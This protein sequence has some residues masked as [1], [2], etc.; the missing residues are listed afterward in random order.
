MHK[1]V[2]SILKNKENQILMIDRKNFPFG[3]ACPAGHVDK[4][5]TAEQA[6]IREV[7]EETG[8]NV[9]KYKLL[10]HEFV[11]WNECKSGIKGHD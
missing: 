6:L 8:L 5:E 2:G 3:W 9:K 10:L 11:E 7:K 4:D 1:S